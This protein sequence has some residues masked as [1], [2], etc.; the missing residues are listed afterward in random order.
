[1]L[2]G[3]LDAIDRGDR[4]RVT[5]TKG[6]DDVLDN[7]N[8]AIKVYLTALDPDLLDHSDSRRLGGIL[9]FITNLEHA[10]DV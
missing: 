9:G 4:N 10:G 1:M 6:L 5:A 7:L 8:R 3:A 2:R